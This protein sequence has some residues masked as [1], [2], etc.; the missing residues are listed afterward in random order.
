VRYTPRTVP[1]CLFVFCLF[2]VCFFKTKNETKNETKRKQ[3][4][5]KTK[6]RAQNE[7]EKRKEKKTK[8]KK[9]VQKKN[10]GENAPGVVVGERALRVRYVRPKLSVLPVARRAGGRGGH[11]F[12]VLTRGTRRR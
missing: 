7:N 11:V 4:K 5:K 8:Q 9:K 1:F 10:E 2:F 12:G 3:K 6:K